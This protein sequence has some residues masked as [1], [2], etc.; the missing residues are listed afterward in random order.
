MLECAAPVSWAWSRMP[1]W[2]PRWRRVRVSYVR[3]GCDVN[4]FFAWLTAFQPTWYS[5]VP[6]MHQAI[7]AQARHN[8]ERA[9]G[10]STT[11]RP[12]LVGSAAAPHLRGTGADFRD[13]RDRVVRDDGNRFLAHRVQSA[14]AAPAQA[15]FGRRTSGFGRR[16]HGRSEG[17]CCPAARRARSS[18]GARASWRATTATRWRPRPRLQAIGSRQGILVSSMTTGTCFSRAAYG[19]SSI[20][21]GR[22]SPPQEVDEVLLEHP[23]V[24]EAVTFAV[25]HATLGEDVASAVVL[26]P[27]AVATPK[28]IRQ[29]AIGRIADFKVPRQV[30]IVR[31]IPKGPTGKVQRI[32]LAAK[33][34][35]ATSTALPRAF[36]APRTPL[37]KVLAERWA[38]ILQVEQIG[39]HDD[40]FASGGDS[41]LATH[42]LSHIYEITHVE[43]EVSRFF[44]APTVAEVAH[45]LETLI[46]AGQA[47]RPSSAIVRVPRENGVVPA[48]IAQ[49]RLW[50]LQQALPGLPFFNI[51]YALR[52][53]SP[54]DAAVLERSI[55]EIVRRHEILRTTFAV[56]DGR[57]VQVIAPQLTVPL[58]FEDLHKLPR[59]RRETAAHQLVQEEAASFLRPRARSPHSG[60]PGAPG[61]AGT[62]LAHLPCTRIIVRWLVARRARRRA[63]RPYDAF[64][65][66]RGIAA[67]AAPDSV[68]RLCVLA[69][70]LAVTSGHRCAARLLARAASRSATR[71]EARHGPS[72]TDNR[73]FPH[74][75]AGGGVA[76][77]AV[78]GRQ[79][80]Q[81]SRRWHVVHGARRRLEDAVASLPGSGRLASGHARRQSQSSGDRRAYRPAGQYGDSPH[82]PRWRPQFSGGD[83]PGSCDNPRSLRPPGSS[84]RRAR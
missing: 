45:H 10:L 84:F 13:P 80:L 55:N 66:G 31:E 6:T 43:L 68:R 72:E 71:D 4:S 25:P 67:G 30:L 42:V 41:L 36:V 50:K 75:A 83:A 17:L 46:Q 35:L 39:I 8:R 23:A 60:S 1:R 77:E 34:G 59:S 18:S 28:D 40:F 20:A 32:G 65:A 54:C 47:P 58:A 48:S 79:T 7:L 33:L 24:A 78:G 27:D 62:P 37:E 22:K 57:H 82:Q 70:A 38:E 9:G 12:L 19:R 3:P 61:R 51:L 52:L 69:A 81:P 49:E 21:V 14:T 53:T 64:S 76:G 15:R 56:V 16:D 11:L 63:R 5:A 44:E 73:R 2:W 74:G 26:R 29:F